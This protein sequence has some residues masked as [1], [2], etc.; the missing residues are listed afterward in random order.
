MTSTSAQNHH[1]G[2]LLNGSGVAL[3]RY[4]GGFVLGSLPPLGK[5]VSS[6][7]FLCSTVG[8]RATV[9]ICV[10]ALG[11]ISWLKLRLRSA[12]HVLSTA[13]RRAFNKAH[14]RTRKARLCARR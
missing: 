13:Y 10:F 4:L 3:H 14:Q 11:A 2:W 1:L 7:A 6:S 8:S 9:K 5:I 12:T